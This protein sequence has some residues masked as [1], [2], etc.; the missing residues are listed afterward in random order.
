MTAIAFAQH[1]GARKIGRKKWVARCSAHPD[2]HPSLSIAEGKTHVL[3]KCMSH[4]CAVEDIVKGFGLRLGDLR[5]HAGVKMDP[6]AIHLAQEA[7]RRTEEH[8][9]NLRIGGY[10]L[11]FL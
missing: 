3:I 8:L 7:R 11:Q 2:N 1:V 10:I 5:L 9:R 4:G 6:K